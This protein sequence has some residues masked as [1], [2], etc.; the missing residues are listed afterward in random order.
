MGSGGPVVIIV[1]AGETAIVGCYE[2]VKLAK[3]LDPAQARGVEAGRK[4]LQ[5]GAESPEEL[6]HKI[7]FVDSVGRLVQ[8]I[9][10]GRQVYCRTNCRPTAK[11]WRTVA[12]PLAGELQN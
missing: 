8:C 1:C 5:L 7:I 9:G 2:V 10:P 4:P 11:F 12:A 3:R 6:Q